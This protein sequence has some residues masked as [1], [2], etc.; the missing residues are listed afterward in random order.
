MRNYWRYILY[1]W[2]YRARVIISIVA[3]FLAE[4][5][6]FASVGALFAA[7]QILLSVRLTGDPGSL[8]QSGV[9]DNRFG[10][11]VL[12]YLCAHATRDHLA[13]AGLVVK[14]R[15]RH[16]GVDGQLGNP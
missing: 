6:N 7:V 13:Q 15:T 8:A 10:R 1:I 11:P 9:F 4:G 3:S 5:L 16:G 12:D 14:Y 2:R